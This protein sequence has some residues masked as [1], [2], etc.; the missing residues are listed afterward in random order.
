ML[1]PSH[2][3]QARL[4]RA[5]SEPKL[6]KTHRAHRRQTACRVLALAGP[7]GL[8]RSSLQEVF[9]GYDEEE[10]NKIAWCQK[11]WLSRNVI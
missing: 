1:G 2:P 9:K 8:Q 3:S 7:W 10:G 6:L 4:K 5:T 11:A